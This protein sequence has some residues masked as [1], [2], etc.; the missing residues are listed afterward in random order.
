MPYGDIVHPRLFG[1]MDRLILDG[2][3]EQ[4]EQLEQEMMSNTSIEY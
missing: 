1:G 3:V 2:G 4:L